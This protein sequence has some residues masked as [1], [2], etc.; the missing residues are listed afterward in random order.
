M[1][2]SGARAEQPLVYQKKFRNLRYPD[3]AV[4][5]LQQVID[6]FAKADKHSLQQLIVYLRQTADDIR[7][8]HYH[9]RCLYT[10]IPPEDALA[11]WVCYVLGSLPEDIR[12]A[13]FT[14]EVLE[15]L[16]VLSL[17]DQGSSGLRQAPWAK[18]TGPSHEVS[19]AL[20]LIKEEYPIFF[21]SITK[22]PLL[23]P[24]LD[25]GLKAKEGNLMIIPRL[26]CLGIFQP[27]KAGED[28]LIPILHALSHI[29][30]Y[31]LTEDVLVMPPGFLNMY[32][33]IFDDYSKSPEEWEEI[34]AE[35]FIASLLYETEYMSL[36]AYMELCQEDQVV[37]RNYFTWL[38]TIF[39]SSLQDNMQKIIHQGNELR[40]A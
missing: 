30:H 15:L 25:F 24:L 19:L 18:I 27:G 1:P 40:R 16:K 22:D 21:H 32:Q 20:A 39:S 35:I 33:K 36:V 11:F 12:F 23:V 10:L 28:S 8:K 26:H 31:V 17:A 7:F 34:F 13:N 38:E 29:L 5:L 14:G 3:E 4:E 9:A 6:Q 2:R 37:I